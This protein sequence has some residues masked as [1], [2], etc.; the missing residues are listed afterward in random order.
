MGVSDPEGQ[1]APGHPRLGCQGKAQAPW[2]RVGPGHAP[3]TWRRGSALPAHVEAGQ[4]TP[5]PREGGAWPPRPRRGRGRA[6]S[7][8]QVSARR[9][10][11]VLPAGSGPGAVRRGDEGSVPA[12]VT[13]GLVR[14]AF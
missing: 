8:Q 5:R 6:G 3:P 13:L 7:G 10:A 4:R 12:Y 1:R 9:R 2:G 14:R 11:S